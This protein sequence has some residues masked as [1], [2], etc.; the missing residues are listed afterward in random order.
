MSFGLNIPWK[1]RA[2]RLAG[3]SE[4]SV[5]L[6]ACC[7]TGDLAFIAAKLTG[8][9]GIVAGIDICEPM[10]SAAKAKKRIKQ[11]A[12]AFIVARAEEI[13]MRSESADVALTAFSLRN[14][15]DLPLFI[16]EMARVLKP[17]GKLVMLETSRPRFAVVALFWRFYLRSVV[18]TLAAALGAPKEPYEYFHRS[19][20]EFISRE[21][22]ASLMSEKG[23]SDVEMHDMALGA[24]C[25]YVGTKKCTEAF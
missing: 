3:I 20:M 11:E 7:G 15:T 8:A 5:V 2:A 12:A 19:V 22:V 23:L 9:A 13:P 21:E 14:V 10:I 24:V 17:G 1:R 25:V 18:P 16:S 4:G 6:D